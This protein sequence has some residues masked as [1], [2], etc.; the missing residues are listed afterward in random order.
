LRRGGPWL[1]APDQLEPLALR[2]RDAVTGI[3][4]IDD[5]DR[6]DLDQVLGFGQRL[7][8]HDGVGGLVV[9]EC[10][11]PR[12]R[13]IGQVLMARKKKADDPIWICVSSLSP[14][15][16]DA[17]LPHLPFPVPVPN[18]AAAIAAMCDALTVDPP[19]SRLCI[20]RAQDLD[21]LLRHR[22][23]LEP[24]GFE[25]PHTI[26]SVKKPPVHHHQSLDGDA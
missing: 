2:A 8:P 12:L 18:L 23:L 16:S 13:D 26:L 14:W 11:D 17:C 6:L 9:A 7:H 15:D 24:G 25:G 1:A 10:R 20:G 5:R 21:V 19:G 22:L 4:S 3:G